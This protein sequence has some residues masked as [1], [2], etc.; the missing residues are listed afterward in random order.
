MNDQS[1]STQTDH[2]NN[3]V[4]ERD[5]DSRHA[6][7][8]EKVWEGGVG[9]VEERLVQIAFV[10]K[11]QGQRETRRRAGQAAVLP[12]LGRH[13]HTGRREVTHGCELP[14]ALSF[15][16]F[17]SRP[18]GLLEEEKSSVIQPNGFISR[19]CNKRTGFQRDSVSLK[20]FCFSAPL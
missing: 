17:S 18:S 14:A 16:S 3:D 6:G 4:N 10:E 20:V 5:E 1:V 8:R 11:Q 7:T 13:L 9:G 2:T 19:V 15:C 12:R